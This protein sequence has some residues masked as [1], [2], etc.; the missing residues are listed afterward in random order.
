MKLKIFA[1]W[2]IFL[3]SGTLIVQAQVVETKGRFTNSVYAY[4]PMYLR[5]TENP[6]THVY[7]YQFL[8]FQAR[9]KEYNNLTL[10]LDTRMLTDLQEEIDNEY[11]FRLNRLTLSAQDLFGGYLDF[12]IGRMFL[13]PGVVF[14]S[15]DGAN[16][17]VK[18]IRDLHVQ[19][20][21][22][23]ESHL[24]R[25]YKLYNFDE[26]TVLGGSVKYFNLLSSN[27]QLSYLQKTFKSDMQWQLLGLNFSN[28]ALNQ[29]N[30]LLQVHYDMANSRLHRIYFSTRYSPFKELYF[31]LNL[32]QQHP[33]IYADSYYTIFNFKEYRQGGLGATY[34]LNDEYSVSANYN[35]FMLEEGQGHRVIASVG[36]FNGSVG[37]VFETGDLGDQVGFMI[38]Y[39]YEFIPGLI[40]SVAIDYT[41]YRFEE[42]YAYEDQL[43]NALRVAYTFSKNIKADLEYQLLNNKFKETD[44]R[45]LNHI[46]IIW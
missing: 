13:H 5:G 14:G 3:M 22:G 29:W 42:I 8:R 40:G 7:L 21:G 36:N 11:R 17:T 37:L 38:D 4:E 43:G 25:S 6:E 41:R 44:H 2:I 35:L 9:I 20:F 31:N 10:N 39:G 46:H 12:K 33:Q 19:V 32:K 24:Y 26:A 27:F 23:V 28:Y 45:I 18:P 15:L 34:Y 16:I 1:L 30:F